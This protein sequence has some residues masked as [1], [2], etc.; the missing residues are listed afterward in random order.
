MDSNTASRSRSA[1]RGLGVCGAVALAAALAAPAGA[2]AAAPT[3]RWKFNPGEAL[4]YEMDQKAVREVKANGQNIKTTVTQ[5]L[6]TVWAVQAVDASGTAEMTQTI[7]RLRTKVD[8][9]FGAVEYDSKSDKQPEGAVA[10]GVVPVYKAL[11]GARFRYK[12]SPQGELS[13]V[14][15][16]EG[17]MKTLREAG[18]TAASSG[19]FTE[20][21]LK[22]MI[23]ESSLVLPAEPLEKPW[24]RQKKIPTPP[25]GDRVED[26]TYTYEGTDP[27][28]EKVAMKIQVDLKPAPDSKFE[29]KLGPQE[30]KGTFYFDNKVGR[31]V[32]STIVRK[33]EMRITVMG[34][35][36][37][38]SQDDTTDVKLVKVDQGKPK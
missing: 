18:P 4:H 36:V 25:I 29:V 15:V 24:T 16:P 30:G 38:Q 28:G 33:L 34:T 12:I 20:D 17:L 10:A 32:R 21:G 13:D 9:P 3:L 27:A 11:V 37:V 14:S 23:R 26:T 22:N 35:Q 6:E 2:R 1:R 5:T 31:V 7:E 8:S 19:M